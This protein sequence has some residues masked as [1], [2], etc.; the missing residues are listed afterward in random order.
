MRWVR[1]VHE[2]TDLPNEKRRVRAF[3]RLAPLELAGET[4]GEPVK[5]VQPS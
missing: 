1:I 2:Y 5:V 3:S 4:D